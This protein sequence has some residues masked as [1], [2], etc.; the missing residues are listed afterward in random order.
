M[1]SARIN[2]VFHGMS[3]FNSDHFIICLLVKLSNVCISQLKIL[4]VWQPPVHK[5]HIYWFAWITFRLGNCTTG[6]CTNFIKT[7]CLYTG[8]FLLPWAVFMYRS[9]CTSYMSNEAFSSSSSNSLSSSSSISLSS[10]FS[11]FC[12]RLDCSKVARGFFRSCWITSWETSVLDVSVK[13]W[14]TIL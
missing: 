7:I 3:K 11:M 1:R 13:L 10:S 2:K 12:Q 9:H 5:D 4:R 6:T 8:I 14:I